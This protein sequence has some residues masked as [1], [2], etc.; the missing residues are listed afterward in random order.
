[1]KV[2][3][4]GGV[5]SLGVVVTAENY[6]AILELFKKA[7]IENAGGYDAKDDRLSGNPNQMNI[8][9]M[10]SDID[11]DANGMETEFQA[12]FEQGGGGVNQ[13]LK[14]KGAGDFEQEEITVIFNRDILINESEAITNCQN[15][16]GIL[17]NET[18]V[19]QHPWTKDAQTEL[20][21]LKK[22]KA[23]AM[24]D[25]MGAFPPRANPNNPNGDT[26]GDQ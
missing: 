15:S 7:L 4:N 3:E 18:I 14:T 23:E 6:K 8:Q 22:E 24:S 1:M 10:D 19:E 17:S 5:D 13:D 20:E 2:R 26:G 12:A 16:V 11:L 21:R 9:S 25:Y